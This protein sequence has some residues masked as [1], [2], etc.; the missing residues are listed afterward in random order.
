VIGIGLGGFVDGLEAGSKF[1]ERRE[2]RARDKVIQERE[3]VEY[4]RAVK[5]RDEISAINTQA[6]T[7]F[8]AKVDA[9]QY[10]PEEFDRFYRNDVVP[11]QKKTLLLQGKQAEAAAWEKWALDSKNYEAAQLTGRALWNLT[12]GNPEAA[13]DAALQASRIQGYNTTGYQIGGYDS[14]VDQSGKK[15]GYRFTLKS[16]DGKDIVQ[17]VPMDKLNTMVAGIINPI[18]VWEQQQAAAADA[19]KRKADLD[20]YTARKGIDAQHSTSGKPTR[21]AAIATLRKNMDGGL[22]G[23]QPKFDDLPS[24]EQERLIAKELALQSGASQ[25]I[26]A[27]PDGVA[28]QPSGTGRKVIVDTATGQP[29]A[30][31]R[32]QSGSSQSAPTE[33]QAPAAEDART[34]APREEKSFLGRMVDKAKEGYSREIGVLSGATG[35]NERNGA[36]QQRFRPAEKAPETRED[37]VQFLLSS[38]EPALREGVSA[39]RVAEELVQN[40]VPESAW[41]DALKAALRADRNSIGLNP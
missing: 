30:P 16:P 9:G 19:A 22:A 36:A 15:L 34:P 35:R 1:R 10:K 13:L 7:D 20:D 40:G 27:F 5:E 26:G 28:P 33:R 4:N 11:R 31:A 37:R 24:A 12:H 29:V 14:L 6:Q 17:D 21:E 8:Q 18:S 41:P 38:V 23:D 32:P 25:A 3:D 2:T 39:K